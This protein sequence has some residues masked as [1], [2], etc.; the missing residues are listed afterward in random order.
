MTSVI[1]N[2]PPTTSI[3]ASD[4]VALPVRVWAPRGRAHRVIVALH[5]M[6]THSGWFARL[7]ALATAHGLAVLAPDR[8]GNG[9]A[10][11]LVRAG[12]ADQLVRDVAAVVRVARDLADEVTLLSWCG[13]ANFAVPAAAALPIDR[14]VLASPG[15]VPLAE[16]AA[17]FRAAEAV[18]G[19]LP[20]HFDPATD[21]TDDAETRL[22]IA[23]DALYLRSIPAGLRDAWRALNPRAREALAAVRVPTRCVLTTTDRMID[24]PATVA[25]L[26]AVPRGIPIEWAPGGHGFVVEPAGAARVVEVLAS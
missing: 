13:S 19:K 9:A 12:D 23:A 24:V 22:A 18:D 1:A 26:E 21:F 10:R 6:V 7:G 25:L 17:R 16:M 20:I 4:G 11:D 15:L 5:G 2:T 14:F 3:V 8:R